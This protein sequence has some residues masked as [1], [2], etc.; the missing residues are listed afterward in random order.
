MLIDLNINTIYFDNFY[1]I[2]I[3]SNLRKLNDINDFILL[4]NPRLT[5]TAQAKQE[6]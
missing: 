6:S 4:P 5:L 2:G 3:T 1:C